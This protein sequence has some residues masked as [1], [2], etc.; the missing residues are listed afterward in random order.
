MSKILVSR[1]RPVFKLYAYHIAKK[2]RN[3]LPKLD[4]KHSVVW[5]HSNLG[6]FG[7]KK[8]YRLSRGIPQIGQTQANFI[9]I[10]NTDN[11]TSVYIYNKQ[12]FVKLNRK[13]YGLDV[14]KNKQ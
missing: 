1:L 3:P 5:P 4:L 7:V 11:N 6:A 10:K 13:T 12:K 8:G 9:V 14:Y 2:I